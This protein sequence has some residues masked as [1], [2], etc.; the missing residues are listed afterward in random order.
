MDSKEARSLIMQITRQCPLSTSEVLDMYEHLQ[1]WES[2]DYI[3]VTDV[4]QHLLWHPIQKQTFPYGYAS[5]MVE[6]AVN[7]CIDKLRY[8]E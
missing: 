2:K 8:E 1:N 5:S 6:D 7:N 4:L 3:S